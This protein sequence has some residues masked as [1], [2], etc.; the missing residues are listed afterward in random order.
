[1]ATYSASKQ[2]NYYINYATSNVAALQIYLQVIYGQT[3]MTVCL[4]KVQSVFSGFLIYDCTI[5]H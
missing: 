5:L 2:L 4:M 1:M 3:T